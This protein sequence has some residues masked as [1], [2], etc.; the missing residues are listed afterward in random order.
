MTL[1]HKTVRLSQ[2]TTMQRF[3]SLVESHPNN[4]LYL[5]SLGKACFDAGDFA[6][7]SEH[8]E[9]AVEQRQD[10]MVPCVLIG[11]CAIQLGEMEKARSYLARALVLAVAGGHEDTRREVIQLMESLG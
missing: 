8:L 10:W 2:T 11:R 9:R 6:Q 7:A 3:Q 1:K 5:F 4:E